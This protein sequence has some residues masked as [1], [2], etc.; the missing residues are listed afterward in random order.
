MTKQESPCCVWDLTLP[1]SQEINRKVIPTELLNWMKKHCKKW[2][3]QLEK[4]NEGYRH[5]QCRMSLKTK[6]R[7]NQVVGYLKSDNLIGHLSRTSTENRDNCFYVCKEET[8]IDGPWKDTDKEIYIPRQVR[9]IKEWLPWQKTCMLLLSTWDTRAI[10]VILDP[11]GNIGKSTFTTFMGCTN[12]AV[13]V[14]FVN[15]YKEIMQIVLDEDKLNAYIIDMPRGMEKSKLLQLYSGIETIKNGFAYDPRYHYKK[16]YFDCPNVLV[17][18]NILPDHKLLSPDRWHVW[19]VVNNELA[20]IKNP[21]GLL[22]LMDKPIVIGKLAPPPSLPKIAPM[23]ALET[24]KKYSFD[25]L[26]H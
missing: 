26:I 7:L 13:Q 23:P 21:F 25:N 6:V 24:P 19:Q 11:E 12:R 8:R 4:G 9:E 20:E 2:C 16:Q 22:D 17:F 15:D 5:F 10:H 14:P 18:T 1:E 3:F